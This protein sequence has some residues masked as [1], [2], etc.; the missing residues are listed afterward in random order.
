[1][2]QFLSNV[3]VKC[4]DKTE[5][6]T[7]HFFVTHKFRGNQMTVSALVRNPAAGSAQLTTYDSQLQQREAGARGPN[8]EPASDGLGRGSRSNGSEGATQ[9]RPRNRSALATA[10]TAAVAFATMLQQAEASGEESC[11]CTSEDSGNRYAGTPGSLGT[12][13]AGMS[14]AVS[15]VTAFFSSSATSSIEAPQ[16]LD[17]AQRVVQHAPA[18]NQSNYEALSS[19][20]AAFGHAVQNHPV[21]AAVAVAA[22][23]T[24]A[25]AAY[26]YANRQPS[27][28]RS[29]GERKPLADQV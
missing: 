5:N 28:G 3:K 2:A 20:G 18:V 9:S 27:E 7:P 11:S 21:T 16:G 8:K 4:L 17:T 6:R 19:A 14:A 25:A 12:F 13:F 26:V 29:T 10:T 23:A 15:G 24:V 22:T 1:M